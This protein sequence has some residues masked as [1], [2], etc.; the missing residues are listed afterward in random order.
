ME[1]ILISGIIV[2]SIGLFFLVLAIW[3]RNPK[4]LQ[5]TVGTLTKTSSFKNFQTRYGLFKNLTDYTYTYSANGKDYGISGSYPKHRRFIP[6]KVEITYLIG[7]PHRAYIGEYT[8]VV[9][10]L[11]ALPFS[12]LGFLFLIIYF[13]QTH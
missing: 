13:V 3:G 8:G 12:F 4:H 7:F 10:W 6:K 11:I 2:L 5:T 1:F 9:E